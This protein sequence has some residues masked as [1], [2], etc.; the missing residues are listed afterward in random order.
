[1]TMYIFRTLT[2]TCPWQRWDKHHEGSREG[3]RRP[4]KAIG[5]QRR[6]YN[7]MKPLLLQGKTFKKIVRCSCDPILAR[8][9]KSKLI[10]D[11]ESENKHFIGT[12]NKERIDQGCFG[13]ITP[14]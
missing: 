11:L 14:T 2:W 8:T 9:A 7:I 4:I 12:G 3:L 13:V 10:L 5:G 1:M 6:S